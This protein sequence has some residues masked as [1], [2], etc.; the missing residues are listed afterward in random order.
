MFKK[1]ESVKRIRMVLSD[2]DS[3]WPTRHEKMSYIVELIVILIY[4]YG[5]RVSNCGE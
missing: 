4:E 2:K 1:R 3:P 5:W